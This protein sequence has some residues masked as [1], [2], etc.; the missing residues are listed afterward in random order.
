MIRTISLLLIDERLA[1]EL[2]DGLE[3]F[4][5]AR[6]V[7]I[8]TNTI[9]LREVISQ[10]LA[11]VAASPR[12]PLWGG[13]LVVDPDISAIVG[14]CG[15]K[16]GPTHDGSI[17]IA[18]FTFPEFE[19]QGYATAMATHLKDLALTSSLVRQII[20]YT[21]P[22]RNPSTRVLEKIGMHRTA[23]VEDPVDGIVWKWVYPI[24]GE[25]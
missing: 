24:T 2:D 21:L 8:V 6:G 20:A 10:T 9:V 3:T 22:E 25:R 15:F 18:Y 23:E 16:S 14:T 4:Q 12:D 19:G 11:M 17:E 1:A 5:A 13:Y 7:R